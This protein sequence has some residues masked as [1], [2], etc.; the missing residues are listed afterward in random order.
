M[1]EFHDDLEECKEGRNIKVGGIDI[2][3]ECLKNN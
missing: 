2:N 3:L 1:N